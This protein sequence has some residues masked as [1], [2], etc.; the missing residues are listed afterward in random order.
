MPRADATPENSRE[1]M[2]QMREKRE[3]P[4]S[5]NPRDMIFIVHGVRPRSEYVLD[6]VINGQRLDS[7]VSCQMEKQRPKDTHWR[8]KLHTAQ[9]VDLF[10]EKN[11]IGQFRQNGLTASHAKKAYGNLVKSARALVKLIKKEGFLK[12]GDGWEASFAV[13]RDKPAKIEFYNFIHRQIVQ[14]D[15]H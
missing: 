3:W 12:E 1:T 14:R 6:G 10:D 5:F 2:R 11:A 8:G 13:H 15:I 9:K 4:F 7:Q